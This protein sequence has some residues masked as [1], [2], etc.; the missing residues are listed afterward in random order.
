[1]QTVLIS[2]ELINDAVNILRFGLFNTKEL[3][4]VLPSGEKK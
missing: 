1:M 3:A 2:H 4:F